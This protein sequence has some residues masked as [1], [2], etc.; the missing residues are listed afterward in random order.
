M[1][2]EYN[3]QSEVIFE[4]EFLNGKRWN[5]K[6]KEFIFWTLIYEGEYKEGKRWN[7]KGQEYNNLHNLIFNG[8]YVNGEKKSIDEK[9]TK[10]N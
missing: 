7:G 4:D 10:E 6:G 8:E 5:G 9:N 3:K 1:G 2:K